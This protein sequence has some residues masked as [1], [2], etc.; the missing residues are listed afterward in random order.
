MTEI[1]FKILLVGDAQ[2][3][4]TSFVDRYVNNEFRKGYKPTLGVD[5]GLKV[6]PWS[7]TETV[8]LQLWDIAGQERFTSMTRVYY[9]RASACII[10][11]DVAQPQTFYS[12]LK[13]KKDL[14]SKCF[15]PNGN[16]IPCILVANK[17]DLP[18][19]SVEKEDI[20]KLCKEHSFL[21][22]TEISVKE[23]K[24]VAETMDFL[25]AELMMP[26]N[27]VPRTPIGNYI[28]LEDSDSEDNRRCCGLFNSE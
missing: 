25:V 9:K 28:D 23:N 14:D 8:R 26:L 22:W 19:R 11:F 6:I 4:K 15:L 1:L 5:F 21:G 17:I 2:V 13:W 18:V 24:H 10:M 20:N 16:P 12:T 7:E 27:G 3:G